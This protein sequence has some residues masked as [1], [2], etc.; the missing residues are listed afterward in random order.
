MGR[1]N[2][3]PLLQRTIRPYTEPN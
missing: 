1:E 2:V 3:F